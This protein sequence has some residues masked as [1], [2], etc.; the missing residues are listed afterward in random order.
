MAT[1]GIKELISRSRMIQVVLADVV[2]VVI[3]ISL[4]E[5]V[6]YK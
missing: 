4:A 2:T 3:M 5:F 1:V 6:L